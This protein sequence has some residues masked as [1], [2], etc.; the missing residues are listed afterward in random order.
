MTSECIWNI[1]SSIIVRFPLNQ[2]NIVVR[3][4]LKPPFWAQKFPEM[5]IS[6]KIVPKTQLTT[7]NFILIAFRYQSEWFN[8]ISMQRY[9]NHRT[10]DPWNPLF[11]PKNAPQWYLQKNV[12]EK[13][14][15]NSSQ[16]DSTLFT[17]Y[18]NY[19]TQTWAS[20]F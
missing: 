5:I 18:K 9:E 14:L 4:V 11:G 10:I 15:P 12:L 2:M 6:P 1:F 13:Q 3:K 8:G 19:I 7:T 16:L 17:F 20:W